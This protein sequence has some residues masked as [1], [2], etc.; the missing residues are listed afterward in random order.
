VP[1]SRA[2][3]P[4]GMRRPFRI[5]LVCLLTTRTRA[6][7]R[8]ARKLKRQTGLNS[9]RKASCRAGSPGA[10]CTVAA[11]AGAL[12]ASRTD[13]VLVAKS[14]AYRTTP[15]GS[16]RIKQSGRIV[17][18]KNQGSDVRKMRLNFRR[19]QRTVVNKGH[20]F[21]AD[22]PRFQ[23]ACYGFRLRV[24]VNLGREKARPLDQ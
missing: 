8:I 5:E 22:V 1:A 18:W 13:A 11:V 15:A 6:I 3:G 23:D 16:R 9:A 14:S 10:S 21:R 12:Q 24:P 4:S 7:L 19:L 20:R 17:A 2:S